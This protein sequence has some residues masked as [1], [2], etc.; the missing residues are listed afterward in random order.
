MIDWSTNDYYQSSN[1]LYYT[2]EIDGGVYLNKNYNTQD[3][4]CYNCVGTENAVKYLGPEPNKMEDFNN[5][6]ISPVIIRP[7]TYKK[8]D[9]STEKFI[10]NTGID[11]FLSFYNSNSSIIFIFVVVLLFLIYVELRISNIIS[12]R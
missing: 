4:K 10:Q 7:T 3:H 9:M 12:N 5:K 11:S 1:N 6:V 8:I 2:N